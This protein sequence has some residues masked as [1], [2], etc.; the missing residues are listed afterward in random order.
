MRQNIWVERGLEALQQ[1]QW[2]DGLQMLQGAVERTS[3]QDQPDVSERIITQILPIFPEDWATLACELVREIITQV[4]VRK[5][6]LEWVRLI[7]MVLTTLR[8]NSSQECIRTVKNQ[9]IMD[10]GLRDNDFLINLE[11]LITEEKRIFPL[12]DLY[13]CKAGLFSKKKDFV[14]CYET[15]Q[16]WKEHVTVTQHLRT[17]LLLAELNAYEIEECPDQM[18]VPQKE[19]DEEAEQ[20]AI[21]R[22]RICRAVE[23]TDQV[24]FNDILLEFKELINS[25]GLLKALCDGITGIF[26]PTQGSG[27]LGSLFGTRDG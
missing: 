18:S 25:D 2:F 20:Y 23:L 21:L 24:E 10:I 6:Q 9:I 14:R 12:S 1:G 13:Y 15:L 11:A 16:T 4:R 17:Y 26:Q 19:V 22:E 8:E 7:P 5:S 3:R 27:L